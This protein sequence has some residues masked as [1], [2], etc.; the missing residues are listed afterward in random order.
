MSARNLVVLSFAA[1]ALALAGADRAA[2]Q[3]SAEASCRAAVA[4][5]T[6]RYVKSV[7]KVVAKCHSTRNKG[8]PL[9]DCNDVAVAD[10]GGRLGK[11]RAKLRATI[12]GAKDRCS[13]AANVLAGAVGSSLLLSGVRTPIGLAFGAFLGTVA[14]LLAAL[15]IIRLM[16][17]GISAFLQ[18]LVARR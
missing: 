10:A 12:G 18:R 3:T 11:A 15:I 6:N 9:P 16:P 5:E 1:A 7:F 2:A 14:L 13:G 17:N 8:G 4:K